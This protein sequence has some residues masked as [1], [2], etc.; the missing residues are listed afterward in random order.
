MFRGTEVVSKGLIIKYA[1]FPEASFSSQCSLGTR[2]TYIC[3]LNITA[4]MFSG[5][6]F[7]GLNRNA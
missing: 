5:S 2:R 1:V 7:W 6:F 4:A 3:S